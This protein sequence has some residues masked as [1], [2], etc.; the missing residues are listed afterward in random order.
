MYFLYMGIGIL[1]LPFF[2]F[3]F[4][5]SLALLDKLNNSELDSKIE[6]ILELL[7][8]INCGACGYPGCKQYAEVLINDNADINLC[9]PGAEEVIQLLSK[10]LN[11]TAEVKL[12]FVAKVFCLG[13]DAVAEKDFLFNGE[14]DCT[15]VFN[16]FNGDKKCKYGC[17]GRGN[18]MRVCPVNAIKRDI[19][20]RV[21]INANECTGC[22]KCISVCPTKVIKIVPINGG[23]FVACSSPE[24]GKIVKEICKKGC[25]GCKTCEKIASEHRIEVTHNLAHVKY[26]NKT[27]LY[28]AAVKCPADVIVPIINQPSFM[29]DNKENKHELKHEIYHD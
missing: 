3:L 14:E 11:K 1:L 17:I 10:I 5:I 21:W 18:C 24:P 20:N 22:E 7:P 15:T 9:I 4:G 12:K 23:H 8:Q 6:K 2:G 13:D 27:D 19:Y 29:Q 28:D 25:I 26:S 16:F